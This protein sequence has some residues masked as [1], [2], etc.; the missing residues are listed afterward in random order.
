MVHFILSAFSAPAGFEW[1]VTSVLCCCFFLQ[2][3]LQTNQHFPTH[4]VCQPL[5]AQFKPLSDPT[6]D[7]ENAFE[8][9][10]LVSPSFKQ[11][12]LETLP[13]VKVV[14]G[15]LWSNYSDL[16]RPHPKWWFN[17]GNLGW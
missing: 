17:Q 4:Q 11:K 13:K 3:H 15:M 14:H 16:T 5:G 9:R 1:T 7:V 8:P 2:N 10:N 12:D 6:C